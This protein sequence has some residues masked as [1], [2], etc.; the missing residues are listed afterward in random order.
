MRVRFAFLVAVLVAAHAASAADLGSRLAGDWRGD[1]LWMTLDPERGQARL[2]PAKPFQW[3]RFII[4]SVDGP[5]VVFTVGVRLFVATVQG[6]SLSVEAPGFNGAQILHRELPPPPVAS[7]LRGTQS[8]SED[9]KPS[10]AQ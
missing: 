6:D 3:E 2:N 7:E 8:A 10:Q 1:K 9:V 4:K 5:Q